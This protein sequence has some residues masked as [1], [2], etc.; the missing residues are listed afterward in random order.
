M[1]KSLQPDGVIILYFKLRHFDL[2]ET[3]VYNI[4]GLQHRVAQI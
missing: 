3:I 2:S 4:M 1:P